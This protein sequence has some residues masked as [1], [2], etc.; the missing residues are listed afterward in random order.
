[1]SKLDDNKLK[2][3]LAKRTKAELVE[4]IMEQ[5][6]DNEGVRR[7]LV[8]LVAPQADTATLTSELNQIIKKAWAHAKQ[9]RAL[10]IGTAHRRRS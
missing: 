10:E 1:M 9:S 4:W 8:T 3:L 2:S 6:T 7:A 5:S